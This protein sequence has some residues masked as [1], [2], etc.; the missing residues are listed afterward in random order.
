MLGTM[1]DSA[2][3]LASSVKQKSFTSQL[4]ACLLRRSQSY[5]VERAAS[6]SLGVAGQGFNLGQIVGNG[7]ED[8]VGH[9]HEHDF[10]KIDPAARRAVKCVLPFSW[11]EVRGETRD[12]PNSK[13]VFGAAREHGLYN[14]F[15]VPVHSGDGSLAVVSF[16]GRHLA[17]DF[18]SRSYLH[19]LAIYFHIA[20]Q[21]DRNS[22]DTR[23]RPT[24]TT[25]QLECLKWVAEGKTDWEIADILCLSEAT[26]NRHIERAKERLGV[27]T[28]V[29]AVVEAINAGILTH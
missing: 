17:N 13:L 8:W 9:Y 6:V 7:K 11:R 16:S 12:D 4:D 5:G 29:Q 1:L 27:R 10:V 20:A 26:I 24:I 19:L 14:G 21:G 22:T 2:V 3:E 18:K 25:R 15:V 23:L 28:R